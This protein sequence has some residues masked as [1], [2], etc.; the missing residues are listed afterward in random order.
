MTQMVDDDADDVMDPDQK[1]LVELMTRMRT[2]LENYVNRALSN[3]GRLPP[4]TTKKNNLY[5]N[6]QTLES[7][8]QL[9]SFEFVAAMHQIR[10]YGNCAAHG[11]YTDLP[12]REEC[13]RV[14]NQYTTLKK[15]HQKQQQQTQLQ[16]R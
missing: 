4:V 6:I 5:Q 11:R 14:V 2:N 7:L 8:G 10:D 13:E 9:P 16:R 1:R 3:I 15:Q 12:T